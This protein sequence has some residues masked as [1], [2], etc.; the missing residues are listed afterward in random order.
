M[1]EGW[2][3]LFDL[4]RG[5]T[6]E[7]HVRWKLYRYL[8]ADRDERRALLN[9]NAPNIFGVL[10][11]VL[12]DDCV[13]RLCRLTDPPSTGPHKS[14]TVFELSSL[15][16]ASIAD[17]IDAEFQSK[18][19]DL[20]TAMVKVRSVR[21]NRIAHSNLALASRVSREPSDDLS[22]NEMD[23]AV[24][25]LAKCLNIVETFFRRSKTFY[26]DV[27]VPLDADVERLFLILRQEG[28]GVAP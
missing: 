11:A 12:F 20:R 26:A 9:R 1:T 17:A 24:R 3:E 27:L 21:N 4:L 25:L 14:A 15:L 8:Y 13:L 16:D 28:A 19:S 18:L 6:I 22:V 10:Q 7:L 5:Q 23:S 2:A